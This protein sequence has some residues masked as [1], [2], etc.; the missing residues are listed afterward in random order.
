L[1]V[2]SAVPGRPAIRKRRSW[3]GF[4]RNIEGYLFISPWIIGFLAFTLGPMIAALWLSFMKWTIFGV[5]QPAGMDNYVEMLTSDARLAKSLGVTFT[6]VFAATPLQQVVA[7]SLAILLNQKVKGQSLFRTIFY[8]PAVVSGVALAVIWQWIFQPDFGLLNTLL[9]EAFGIKGPA[10][11]ASETWALPALII[12][13]VWSVGG[14]MVIYLA[15]LQNVP[16]H[17]YEA[18]E[19]DGAGNAS[20]FRHITLPM[21]SPVILFNLVIGIIGGFQT[22]TQA[23][24][25]T[26]G[27]PVDAT[28]FYNFYLYQRAF[29]DMRM[30]Y[31]S[32]MA[33]LMFLIILGF[34]VI[35]FWLSRRWVYYEGGER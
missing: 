17:L 26:Q 27:G 21:I 25:M 4:Q 9:K 11:L 16:E 1:T 34:T 30:G 10:W 29:R 6:Y 33:W 13:S 7:L 23:F 28:L 18:A 19:L 24:V 8:L 32:A 12:M 22:F 2:D 31:A 3:R 20:K 5:P 14:G 35:Q 15:S